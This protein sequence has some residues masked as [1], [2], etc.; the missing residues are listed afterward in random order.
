MKIRSRAIGGPQVE[1]S[2]PPVEIEK[3]SSDN[4]ACGTFTYRKKMKK[5]YMQ[6]SRKIFYK[7]FRKC[8][9]AVKTLN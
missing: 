4:L 1:S 7:A 5:N 9:S 6:F 2:W 8:N 3:F